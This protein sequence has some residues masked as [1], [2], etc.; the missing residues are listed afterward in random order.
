M[1]RVTVIG[2]DGP[3]GSTLVEYL[4]DRAF[5]VRAVDPPGRTGHRRANE[6]MTA[7]LTDAGQAIRAV[8]GAGHV[9]VLELALPRVRPLAGPP[10]A[11]GAELTMLSNILTASVTTRVNRVLYACPAHDRPPWT[12]L[13]AL[14]PPLLA[15]AEAAGVETRSALLANVYGAADRP[16]GSISAIDQLVRAA[17][18]KPM[19]GRAAM[20]VGAD[21]A[22][23]VCHAWDCAIAVYLLMRS[24]HRQPLLLAHRRWHSIGEVA[25]VLSELSLR[26]LLTTGAGDPVAFHPPNDVGADLLGVLA[27]GPPTDLRSGLRALLDGGFAVP[28]E[29]QR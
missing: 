21:P 20:D 24:N 7:E 10:G 9:Y 2:T 26:P 17:A 29:G 18:G 25:T 22:V 8:G 11:L 3:P 13:R 15:D 27:W 28:T 1:E 5:W 12:D 19:P 23:P 16:N 6:R 4:R 14:A